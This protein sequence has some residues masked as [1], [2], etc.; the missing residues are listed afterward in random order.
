MDDGN[1]GE[2]YFGSSQ[3]EVRVS[4]GSSYRE[5]TKLLINPITITTTI[6]TIIVI[7]IILIVIII[8]YF[9]TLQHFRARIKGK[10]LRYPCT[11]TFIWMCLL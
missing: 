7:I 10:E 5:S 11:D 3:E 4:E 2:I 1:P 9:T 6:I 8:M